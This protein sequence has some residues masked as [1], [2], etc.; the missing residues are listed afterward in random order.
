MEAREA[1]PFDVAPPKGDATEQTGRG[2]PQIDLASTLPVLAGVLTLLRRLCE[3]SADIAED[4][5]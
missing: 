2:A 3:K 5:P 1:G 4:T